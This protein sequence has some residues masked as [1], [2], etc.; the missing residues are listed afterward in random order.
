MAASETSG[1]T[2]ELKDANL[3]GLK[4]NTINNFNNIDFGDL[5]F[6]N[7]TTLDKAF[8][9]LSMS[10]ASN[11]VGTVLYAD[12]V[13]GS[14]ILLTGK[15]SAKDVTLAGALEATGNKEIVAALDAGGVKVGIST[16]TKVRF[17]NDTSSEAIE[18]N[19][20]QLTAG[21]TTYDKMAGKYI[22]ASGKESGSGT[23]TLSATPDAA[24]KNIAGVYS[25]DISKVATGGTLNLSGGTYAVDVKVY[26][27]YSDGGTVTGNNLNISGG[28]FNF[29]GE[30]N[31]HIYGGSTYKGTAEGNIIDISGA[32]T[33]IYKY[34]YGG[35]GKNANKNEVK[36]SNGTLNGVVYG[37]RVND[38]EATENSVQISGGTINSVVYGG[39]SLHIGDSSTSKA[40]DNRVVISGGTINSYVVGGAGYEA[41]DNKIII[42]QGIDKAAS[43]VNARLEGNSKETMNATDNNSLIIENLGAGTIIGSVKNFNS[44]SFGDVALG[45]I[46]YLTINDGSLNGTVIT[47]GKLTGEG[48]LISGVS[49]TGVNVEALKG[50]AGKDKITALTN[51]VQ[52][53]VGGGTE[54]TVNAKSIHVKANAPDTVKAL[55]GVFYGDDGKAEKGITDGVLTLDGSVDPA[56]DV[57]YAGAYAKKGKASGGTVKLTGNFNGTVYG[58][59]SADGNGAENNTLEI[60]GS[61]SVTVN[62][63]EAVDTINITGKVAKNG[64]KAALNITNKADFTKANVNIEGLALTDANNGDV[65]KVISNASVDAAKVVIKNLAKVDGNVVKANIITKDVQDDKLTLTY[66]GKAVTGSYTDEAGTVA[67]KDGVLRVSDIDKF[68]EGVIYTGAYSSNGTANGTVDLDNSFAGTLYGYYQANGENGSG[69]L[70]VRGKD[71]VVKKIANFNTI[72]FFVPADMPKDGTVLKVE[73]EVNIAGAKVNAG[74]NNQSAL[75]IGD[76]ITL[77]EAVSLNATGIVAGKVTENDFIDYDMNIE[78]TEKELKAKITSKGIAG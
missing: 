12:S 68:V 54:V 50:E 7:N 17:G 76:E 56:D 36:I 13:N 51:G 42:K 27:G 47:A 14:G 62:K 75:D 33:V 38:G 67:T 19:Y 11:L 71:L 6:A 64:E 66:G 29:T 41:K 53:A 40:N 24:I 49:T 69:T 65:Y 77:L 48:D 63:I 32:D 52:Y 74:I 22:D 35:H 20:I 78:A 73:S 23:L 39:Y 28:T 44:I 10:D 59:Y 26:G 70:N 3:N 55:T 37:S 8:V 60:D 57:I 34:I 58:G 15:F 21:S 1:N 61:K 72:N 4:V 25:N 9:A 18:N 31:G 16:G 5:I 45:D 43:L 2:L 30:N 46:S